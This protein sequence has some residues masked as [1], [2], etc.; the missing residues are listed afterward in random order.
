MGLR[1]IEKEIRE[2][3]KREVERINSE[4]ESETNKIRKEI[5]DMAESLSKKLRA[6]N[7]KEMELE[8][9]RIVARANLHIKEQAER[10]KDDI[11]D[12]VFEEARNRVMKMGRPEKTRLLRGFA[13]EGKK[14]L[15]RPTVWI[16]RKFGSLPGA[17]NKDIGDFGVVVTSGH[18]TVDNTLSSKLEKVKSD[19]RHK[20]A[21]V[22][23]PG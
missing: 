12:S 11:I 20:V 7:E 16:D 6:R 22:L 2:S 3:G 4:A 17:K 15:D 14:G 10:K 13:A 1:E 9:K 8:R 23:W 18:I 19:S 21:E 5:D